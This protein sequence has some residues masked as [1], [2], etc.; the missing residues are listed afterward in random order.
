MK[1]A[2]CG[3]R[4]LL[5][6][7]A[8]LVGFSSPAAAQFG[9]G[10][11]GGT[12]TDGSGGVLPGVTVT[13]SNPG[14]IGGDQTAVSDAEGA[15]QFTRLVPGSYTVKGELQGFRSFVQEQIQV[16]ADRASRVD[17]KMEVG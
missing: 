17:L 3:V 2:R 4:A 9:V 16:N 13:L 12:V 8:C 7:L 11:I 10:S 5:L 14:V 15:F 1:S 6:L